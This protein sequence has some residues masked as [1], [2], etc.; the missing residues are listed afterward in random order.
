MFSSLYTTR[1]RSS[2]GSRMSMVPSEELL[3][4]TIISLSGYFWSSTDSRQRLMKRPLLYVTMVT[5]TK[6]LRDMY[7]KF[8]SSRRNR[9]YCIKPVQ[10]SHVATTLHTPPRTRK[11]G[12]RETDHGAV[13]SHHSHTAAR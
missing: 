7:A 3:S 9:F 13:H 11:T 5:E 12:N 2:K 6:S 8:F 1:Q 4:M 10:P